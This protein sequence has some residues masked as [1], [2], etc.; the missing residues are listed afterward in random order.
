MTVAGIGEGIVAA[1]TRSQAVRRVML[2]VWECYRGGKNGVK[3]TDARAVRA[4]QYDSWAEVDES[5][6]CWDELAV[7]R[8]VAA[9]AGRDGVVVAKP[10]RKAGAR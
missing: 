3:W 2:S 9:P 6:H 10:E 4:P 5:K 1:E 8:A 7:A